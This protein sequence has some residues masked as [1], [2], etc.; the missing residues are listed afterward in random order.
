MAIDIQLEW[1][2]QALAAEVGLRR[3]IESGRSG[4][5]SRFTSSLNWTA[6]LEGASGEMAFAKATGRYWSGSVNTYKEGG[7]VGRIQVR[8][9]MKPDLP[10][11][12]RPSDR[13]DDIFVLVTGSQGTYR[14]VGWCMGAEGKLEQY[15]KK[16]RD[17]APTYF[18]PHSALHNPK[19]LVLEEAD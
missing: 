19:N 3:Y 18:V 16:E 6:H 15:L 13:D 10:L 8:M 14:V 12:I 2:E 9:R 17:W 7:D 4:K 11:Y 1:Y 5:K